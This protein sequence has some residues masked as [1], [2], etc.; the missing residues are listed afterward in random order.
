MSSVTATVT[1]S[2]SLPQSQGP[3]GHMSFR[4][5][6]GLGCPPS[7]GTAR[8]EMEA[9]GQLR[10]GAFSVSPAQRVTKAG[11]KWYSHQC[12]KNKDSAIF[13]VLRLETA[14][15]WEELFFSVKL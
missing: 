3:A 5:L 14:F 12:E 1:G 2:R 9:A 15:S 11:L 10:T 13:Y 6:L 4:L 8:S 7:G